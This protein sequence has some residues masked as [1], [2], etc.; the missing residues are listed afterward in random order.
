MNGNQQN[1]C[2][3][4]GTKTKKKKQ[5]SVKRFLWSLKKIHLLRLSLE[6]SLKTCKGGVDCW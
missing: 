1:M 6:V 5:Q 4:E 3:N 2:N